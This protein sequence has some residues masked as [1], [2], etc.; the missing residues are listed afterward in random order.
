MHGDEMMDEAEDSSDDGMEEDVAGMA[1]VPFEP[2][3][4]STPGEG[5]TVLPC[6]TKLPHDLEVGTKLACWFPHPYNSWFVGTIL[7]INRWRTKTDNVLVQFISPDDGETTG[8]LIADAE[9]YGVDKLWVVLYRTIPIDV[10]A[11]CSGSSPT[12]DD[13]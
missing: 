3:D 2:D 4:Y 5:I 11:E 6:P 13:D 12:E 9:T 8:I 7:E 10:D 1:L